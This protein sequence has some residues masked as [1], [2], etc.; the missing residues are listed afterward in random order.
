MSSLETCKTKLGERYTATV[1]GK[2]ER[3]VI[4]IEK[5]KVLAVN[6]DLW[7][8]IINL[9][10]TLWNLFS[11]EEAKELLEKVQA[12][13]KQGLDPTH[14]INLKITSNLAFIHRKMKQYE[15]AK[16]LGEKVIN[17]GT[18]E[19]GE[20]HFV[21][22]GAMSNYAL[23]LSDLGQKKS[24]LKLEK[25]VMKI[26]KEKLSSSHS[27]LPIRKSN[28]AESLFNLGELAAAENLQREVVNGYQEKRGLNHPDTII[29]YRTLVV[30]LALQCKWQEAV[31]KI[32]ICIKASRKVCG[33]GERFSMI[34]S[35][36]IPWPPYCAARLASWACRTKAS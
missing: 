11:F 10:V 4:S 29:S 23:I 36:L 1:T 19:L 33:R 13:T 18:N 20:D 27:S 15:R 2:Y 22:L 26:S 28:L 6:P 5:S 12:G 32:R 31:E 9:A 34:C 3:N 25:K 7:T 16:N 30:T 35:L 21:T 24:A 14:P 8:N 17:K